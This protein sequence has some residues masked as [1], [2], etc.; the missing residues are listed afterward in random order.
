MICRKCG[1]DKDESE[2]TPSQLKRGHKCK[3]CRAEYRRQ[4]YSNPKNKA[5]Q[6]ESQRR[7]LSDPANKERTK[8]RQNKRLENPEV[9]N[10]NIRFRINDTEKDVRRILCIS[11]FANYAASP[12]RLS[13]ATATPSVLRPPKSLVWT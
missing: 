2:F 5:Q 13:G 9:K 3:A 6:K 10:A 1:V 12:T 4:W 11:L 7:W 8:E